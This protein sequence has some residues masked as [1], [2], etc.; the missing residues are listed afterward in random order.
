MAVGSAIVILSMLALVAA[1]R[2]TV[3]LRSSADANPFVDRGGR[4]Q[5]ELHYLY[6]KWWVP[7]PCW[8]V[9]DELNLDSPRAMSVVGVVRI[10]CGYTFDTCRNMSEAQQMQHTFWSR[11]MDFEQHD[12][13]NFSV[14]RRCFPG[15]Y[16]VAFALPSQNQIQDICKDPSRDVSGVVGVC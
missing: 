4:V 12:L 6:K 1:G 13:L 8:D 16:L 15:A 14:G 10:S 3:R 11:V 9:L 2:E 5:R 7:K